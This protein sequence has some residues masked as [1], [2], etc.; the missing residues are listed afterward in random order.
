MGNGVE[1]SG[2]EHI[3]GGKEWRKF[4]NIGKIAVKLAIRRYLVGD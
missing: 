1:G 3:A 2:R 4:T